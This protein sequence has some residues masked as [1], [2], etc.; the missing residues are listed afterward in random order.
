MG[1]AFFPSLNNADVV[2]VSFAS[3]SGG[4]LDLRLFVD[5]GFTGSSWF[6]LPRNA[7]TLLTLPAPRRFM[8][9]AHSRAFN[10]G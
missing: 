8:P 7:T 1:I 2:Q 10:S 5:T 6:V 4:Y 9:L 3:T